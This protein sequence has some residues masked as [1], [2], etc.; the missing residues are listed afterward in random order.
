LKGGIK[1][2]NKYDITTEEKW[3]MVT[4]P[5]PHLDDDDRLEKE[6][7]AEALRVYA[8]SEATD[9]EDGK[10][11]YALREVKIRQARKGRGHKSGFRHFLREHNMSR[12]TVYRKLNA[13]AKKQ[14]LTL[15]G[16]SP[17]EV[18][19]P[20]DQELENGSTPIP[21][22]PSPTAN[23]PLANI[24]DI[25]RSQDEQAVQAFLKAHIHST[26]TMT[27]AEGVAEEI[28]K[29]LDYLA[30]QFNATPQDALRRVVE[31]AYNKEKTNNAT[32]NPSASTNEPAA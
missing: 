16:D 21:F 23:V 15:H 19:D 20:E 12:A 5:V 24:T 2:L 29:M 13:Y 10:T 9:E 7:E 27:F 22:S 25:Q 26:L 1:A 3:I 28:R 18:D 32:T 17:D 30:K 11:L 8:N 4:D 6:L 31:Q 14:S